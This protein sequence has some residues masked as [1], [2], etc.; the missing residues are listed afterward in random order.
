MFILV[1]YLIGALIA[2]GVLCIMAKHINTTSEDIGMIL[3][4]TCL[5]WITIFAII[6]IMYI[7]KPKN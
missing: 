1:I 6:Q 2:G 7:D 5:S 4:G 3:V